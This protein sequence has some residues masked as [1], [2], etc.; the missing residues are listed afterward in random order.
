MDQMKKI[1]ASLVLLF[2][3]EVS[4][5]VGDGNSLAEEAKGFINNDNNLNWG[6]FFGKVAGVASAWANVNAG[7]YA[8]CYPENANAGQLAKITAK[9]LEE[10]PAELHKDGSFLIWASHVEA[11]GFQSDTACAYHDRWLSKNS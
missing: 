1:I 6:L 5:Y 10:N 7:P 4:A 8:V 11:F 2:A 3:Q 9:Y